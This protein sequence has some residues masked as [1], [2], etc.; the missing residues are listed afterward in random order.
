MNFVK[1]STEN[2]FYNNPKDPTKAAMQKGAVW[3]DIFQIYLVEMIPSGGAAVSLR[4]VTAGGSI[5][6]IHVLEE[7]IPALEAALKKHDLPY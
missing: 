1:L 2:L 6:V 3:I 7:S 5:R 4:P